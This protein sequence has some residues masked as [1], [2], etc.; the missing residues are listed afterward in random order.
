MP[1]ASGLFFWSAAAQA[2]WLL[3]FLDWRKPSSP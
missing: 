1:A 2:A 3:G